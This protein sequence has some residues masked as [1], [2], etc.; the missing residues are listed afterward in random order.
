MP[1]T[2][3]RKDG[4]ALGKGSAG[5]SWPS[6]G[7]LAGGPGRHNPGGRKLHQPTSKQTRGPSRSSAAAQPAPNPQVKSSNRPATARLSDKK[8]LMA[9][10][11]APGVSVT[12]PGLAGPCTRGKGIS[13]EVTLKR[14]SADQPQRSPSEE[15]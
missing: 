1:P 9:Q 7:Q 14:P 5:L 6:E 12:C 11:K 3:G 10:K 8:E 2:L 15:T 13:V 4:K